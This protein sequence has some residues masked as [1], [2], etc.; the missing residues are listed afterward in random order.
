MVVIVN[1]CSMILYIIPNLVWF[2]I[3]NIPL[4]STCI[5]EHGVCVCVCGERV[6]LGGSAEGS[7]LSPGLILRSSIIG[8][9]RNCRYIPRVSGILIRLKFC[10]DDLSGF[11]YFRN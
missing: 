3:L 4:F 2:V 7:I 10:K 1:V 9:N 6:C 11:R 5:S 8:S